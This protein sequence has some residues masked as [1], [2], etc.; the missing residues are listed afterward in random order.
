[1]YLSLRTPSPRV[2]YCQRVAPTPLVVNPGSD[3]GK[4]DSRSA[5]SMRTISPISSL[6]DDTL[7]GDDREAFLSSENADVVGKGGGDDRESLQGSAKS[8]TWGHERVVRVPN[9]T[10][11]W[12]F[13]NQPQPED[14][15]SMQVSGSFLV[16]STN[17]PLHQL[18][19]APPESR[20][21]FCVRFRW[22][23][24]SKCHIRIYCKIFKFSN[25]PI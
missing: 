18:H 10:A 2:L 12:V 15:I 23:G 16:K 9:E 14:T 4:D 8:A 21:S 17:R 3:N 13:T 25:I 7:D 11:R 20:E 5:L 22:Q 24:W 19:V 6:Q 1:M